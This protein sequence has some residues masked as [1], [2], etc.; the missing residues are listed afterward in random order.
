MHVIHN[1]VQRQLMQGLHRSWEVTASREE[2]CT[3]ELVLPMVTMMTSETCGII[4][5]TTKHF[6]FLKAICENH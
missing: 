6:G 4:L 5:H 1:E 2:L 3:M